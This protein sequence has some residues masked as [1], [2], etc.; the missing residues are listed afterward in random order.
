VLLGVL[1]AVTVIAVLAII[2]LRGSPDALAEKMALAA[3]GLVLISPHTMSYD[4]SLILITLVVLGT[5]VS[6]KLKGVAIVW[7][8]AWS[9]MLAVVL[10]WSPLFLVVLGVAVWAGR[11]VGRTLPILHGPNRTRRRGRTRL[12]RSRKPS[13][14]GDRVSSHLGGTT[15][16]SRL[17]STRVA[18]DRY[19]SLLSVSVGAITARG[20]RVVPQRFRSERA[21]LGEQGLV[22][23]GLPTTHLGRPIRAVHDCRGHGRHHELL[24]P[25]A[26]NF[27]IA[28]S[29]IV[30]AFNEEQR[31]GATLDSIGS[32]VSTRSGA[33]EV[34]VID[35]G[36][37]DATGAVAAA[38]ACP[39]LNV[40]RVDRNMGKGHAVRVG[41]LAAS[42]ERRLFMDADE[43]TPIH[44]LD[45]LQRRLDAIGG[46]GVAF[47]S[48]AVP[49]ADVL[50][51]QSR[52]R[53]AAGRLGNRLIQATVL[54]GV[55]DSQRGFKLFSADAAE[56]IFSR[57]VVNGWGFDVEVLALAGRLGYEIVEVPVEWAHMGDSR[58]TAI[59]Y[60][61]TL[62]DV[63]RVRS[64]MARGVY[65]STAR[66]PESVP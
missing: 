11:S 34:I 56:A 14:E 32:F 44:E 20:R 5:T 26:G 63:F 35:D 21:P 37:L 30:P 33:T 12:L 3:V 17:R 48:I 4:G 1:P 57:C 28:L 49:G 31:I 50:R 66:A 9:Q 24:A 43:S 22:T 59:S 19:R 40:I 27:T 8:A 38:S 23:A 51:S 61:A 52:L 41:M 65:D 53:V 13:R 10:G 62:A 42:G 2:W 29:V 39:N 45:R 60:I 15:K 25:Y 46:S 36:S 7:V 64:R 18:T 54:P 6:S 47:G 58:V 55:G 16:S